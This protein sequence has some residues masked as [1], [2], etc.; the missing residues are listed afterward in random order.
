MMSAGVL[1]RFELLTEMLAGRRDVV[2]G[3]KILAV[4]ARQMHDCMD[5]V[6]EHADGDA[7]LYN[8]FHPVEP[9]QA[10]FALSRVF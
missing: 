10:R 1:Q 2:S 4:E 8:V 7:G 5:H 6:A 3:E 9:F